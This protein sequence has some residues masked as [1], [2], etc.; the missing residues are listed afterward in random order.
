MIEKE[1]MSNE[2]SYMAQLFY[3]YQRIDDKKLSE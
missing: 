2:A 1:M 3:V